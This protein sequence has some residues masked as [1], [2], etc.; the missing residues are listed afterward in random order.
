MKISKKDLRDW[1]FRG[2]MF[3]AEAERFRSAGIR[4]GADVFESERALFEEALSPFGIDARNEALR[5]ARL[6]SLVYCFENAVRN[7]IKDRLEER[8]GSSWW[9]DKV[10][11]R[12]Q[13]FADKRQK[14]AIKNS[15]LEG[16]KKSSLGFVQFGHLADIIIEN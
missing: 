11:R 9:S 5:M 14:D 2:L 16:D 1:M 3:E 8:Y 15:W 7:L 10:P 13:E 12:I 4:V 6:Y